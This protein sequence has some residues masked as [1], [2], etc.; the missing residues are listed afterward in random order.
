PESGPPPRRPRSARSPRGRA[1]PSP[2]AESAAAAPRSRARAHSAPRRRR[3]TSCRSSP[4]RSRG[5]LEQRHEGPLEPAHVVDDRARRDDQGSRPARPRRRLA[6]GEVRVPDRIGGV[7]DAAGAMFRKPGA[8][9]AATVPEADDAR[10]VEHV[11]IPGAPCVAR[12]NRHPDRVH[13]ELRVRVS[14]EYVLSSP[15]GSEA[16]DRSGGRDQQDQARLAR[17]LVEQRLELVDAP[18]IRER[19]AGTLVR[20]TAAGC[21]KDDRCRDRE[22][23]S[24]FAVTRRCRTLLAAATSTTAAAATTTTNPL[25]SAAFRI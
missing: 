19:G 17:P 12:E 8:G 1:R 14:L 15:T 23:D 22:C 18:E 7:A 16:A 3:G 20:S 6:E 13:G 5:S 9:D 10:I 11:R 4:D 21:G 24:H 25:P 2:R